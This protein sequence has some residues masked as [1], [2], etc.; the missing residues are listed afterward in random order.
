M[1]LV[2]FRLCHSC[3]TPRPS[4]TFTN[5]EDASA[6]SRPPQ[7]SELVR[8]PFLLP[9]PGT[10]RILPL[11]VDM[12]KH[13]ARLLQRT[14][15]CLV[16]EGTQSR[17]VCHGRETSLHEVPFFLSHMTGFPICQIRANYEVP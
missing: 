9:Y 17:Q 1:A 10:S 3:I 6:D 12:S 7:K 14:G 4:A 15:N 16:V 2:L 8:C 5:L 13:G 11:K